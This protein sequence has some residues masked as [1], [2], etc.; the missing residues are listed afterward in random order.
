MSKM[1]RMKIMIS[2]ILGVVHVWKRKLSLKK[3][4]QQLLQMLVKVKRSNK[5]TVM[6]NKIQTRKRKDLDIQEHR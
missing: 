4:P 6:K 3:T 1:I 2:M 5:G